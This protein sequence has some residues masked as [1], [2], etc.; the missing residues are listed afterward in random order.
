MILKYLRGVATLQL[1]AGKCIGCGMCLNVCPHAVFKLENRKAVVTDA[2]LCME[3]GACALNCPA[4]AIS[5]KKGVGLRAGR[6]DGLS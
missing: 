2:D 5:V 3:C 6:A 4:A 1:D